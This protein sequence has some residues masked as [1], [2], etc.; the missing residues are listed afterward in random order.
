MT[1]LV[2]GHLEMVKLLIAAG[3]KDILKEV[4]K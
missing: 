2:N 1:A 3:E 4:Y